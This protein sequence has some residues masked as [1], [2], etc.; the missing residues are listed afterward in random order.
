MTLEEEYRLSCYEELTTLGDHDH[1]TLVKNKL[2]G[3]IYVKKV[4]SRFSFDVYKTLMELNLPGIP[5]IYDLI[6]N[7]DSLILIE[8]YIHGQTLEQLLQEKTTLNNHDSYD[9]LQK[10]CYILKS[11]HSQNPPIVHRDLKLSNI[12]LTHDNLLYIVDFDTARYFEANKE[13]DTE[14]LGTREYASPEQYGFGQSDPRSD[15]YALG[16]ILNRLLTGKY[17]KQELYAGRYQSVISKC[18]C[19]DPHDRFQSVDDLITALSQCQHPDI[20]KPGISLSLPSFDFPG[21]RSGKFWKM[22]LACFGYILCIYSCMTMDFTEAY[23][24]L[25]VPIT[26][27]RLWYE[28][29]FILI[30]CL[31]L[32]FYNT[33]YKNIKTFSF[34]G[35]DFPLLIRIL[36]QC[37]VSV[38][39][40]FFLIIMMMIIEEIIW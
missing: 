11:L 33:D 10:I 1:I 20:E 24:D 31:S 9:I 27:T 18:I 15:I 19:L 36:I 16:V 5:H 35:K 13:Q 32:I 38:L 21:F 14:L 7:D 3:E 2:S 34:H 25:Q 17:P 29:V 4:L 8:D 23:Q 39:I 12:I 30:T 6:L 28:R 22:I 37:L 40:T 26:G